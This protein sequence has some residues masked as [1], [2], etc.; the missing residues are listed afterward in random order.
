MEKEELHQLEM[1]EGARDGALQSGQVL[2]KAKVKV[3][4]EATQEALMLAMA[5]P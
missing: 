1:C 2:N 3:K 5:C 4:D